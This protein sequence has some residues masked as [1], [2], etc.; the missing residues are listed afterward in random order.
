VTFDA[1]PDVTIKLSRRLVDRYNIAGKVLMKR[2]FAA[3]LS[4]LTASTIFVGQTQSSGTNSPNGSSAPSE[5]SSPSNN[6]V[7]PPQSTPDQ[8]TPSPSQDQESQKNK[9]KDKKKKN[10]SSVDDLSVPTAF[11]DAVASDVLQQLAD[12][13]EGHSERLMLSA[14]DDN[15]MDGYL[16]FE[17][18]IE[19]FFRKY[20]SFRIH[21]RIAQATTEGDK[22][23]V[24]VDLE[25]DEM[26]RSAS[27]QPVR[28]RDQMRFEMERGK[29]G[30]K[31]V[32]L[33]PRSFF[34]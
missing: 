9:K 13:L 30:W 11:S 32:D 14:F 22:G 34:S 20:D 16:N 10:K 21:Y 29:K 26:P 12:G 27:V 6:T 4:V 8:S 1:V 7:T 2:I 31:I 33:R 15:K 28:K 25:M 24:L 18:Q 3:C 23:V 17:D 5:S 19:A